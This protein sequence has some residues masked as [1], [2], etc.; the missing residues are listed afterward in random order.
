MKSALRAD[1]IT[2]TSTV[3]E[4]RYTYGDTTDE[5]VYVYVDGYSD[6]TT[7]WAFFR[8]ALGEDLYRPF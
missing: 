5:T 8:F 7:N 4:M 6:G 2:V 1:K 3:S